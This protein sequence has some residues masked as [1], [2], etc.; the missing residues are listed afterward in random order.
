M[1]EMDYTVFA[2]LICQMISFISMLKCL[3]TDASK[4]K[5][6]E[7]DDIDNGLYR[8]CS[9]IEMGKQ[10]SFTDCCLVCLV[11]KLPHQNHCSE[12]NKCILNYQFHS[13]IYGKCIGKNNVTSYFYCL[14]FLAISSQLFLYNYITNEKV[15]KSI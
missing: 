9:E 11:A 15:N 1:L 14:L 10:C 5:K 4:I 13:S 6:Y 8:M 7:L 3:F 12:C 2:C